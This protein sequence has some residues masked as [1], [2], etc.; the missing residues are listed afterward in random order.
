VLIVTIDVRRGDHS[1]SQ[2]RNLIHRITEAAI[3]VE[4]EV[5]R[6][7]VFVKMNEITADDWFVGGVSL[8]QAAGVPRMDRAD[9]PN[10]DANLPDRRHALRRL[11]DIMERGT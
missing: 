10:R 3:E 8:D 6:D 9:H 7:Q 1:P 11:K 5:M 2:K 4:G